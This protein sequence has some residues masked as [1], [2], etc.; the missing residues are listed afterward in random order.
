MNIT[1]HT[2]FEISK[3]GF[4]WEPYGIFLLLISLAA[5][6]TWLAR[7][8]QSPRWKGGLLLVALGFALFL[9]SLFDSFSRYLRL[10]RAYERNDYSLVE[11]TV[12]DFRPIPPAGHQEECF[13]VKSQRFCYSDAGTPAF[14][15]IVSRGSPIKAGLHVRIAYIGNDILRLEIASGEARTLN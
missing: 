1:Y 6:I 3:K 5:L 13:T 11:G 14:N 8:K 2:A 15:K 9:A 7:R 10:Q 4:G 12:E